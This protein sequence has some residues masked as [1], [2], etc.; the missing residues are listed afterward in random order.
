VPPASAGSGLLHIIATTTAS[1]LHSCRLAW[2]SGQRVTTSVGGGLVPEAM[3]AAEHFIMVAVICV[4]LAVMVFLLF[5]AAHQSDRPRLPTD[6]SPAS[7]DPAHPSSDRDLQ[8][9]DRDLQSSD[10]D[11][12]PLDRSRQAEPTGG[13]GPP[14]GHHGGGTATA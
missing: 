8:S 10:R 5:L 14:Y 3:S 2:G 4:S 6:H 1:L 13:S 11:L 12:Q 7:S 9:S